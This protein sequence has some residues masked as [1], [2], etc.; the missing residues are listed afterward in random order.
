MDDHEQRSLS[1][2]QAVRLVGLGIAAATAPALSQPTGQSLVVQ[3][4]RSSLLPFMCNWLQVMR[5][6]QPATF[7]GQAVGRASRNGSD[8]DVPGAACSN[9]AA[10][11]T[12]LLRTTSC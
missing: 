9:P 4:S 7:T 12:T 3:V 6:L 1:R 10:P 11:Y 2:R 8:V 5:V